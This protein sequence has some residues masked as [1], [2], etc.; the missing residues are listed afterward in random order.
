MQIKIVN[1]FQNIRPAYYTAH[2]AGTDFSANPAG[3]SQLEPTR[4]MPV[5][6]ALFIE[7]PGDYQASLKT[8][9]RFAASQGTSFINNEY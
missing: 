3:L 6:K 7:L 2:S 9:S 4:Q 1:R 8:R 5:S